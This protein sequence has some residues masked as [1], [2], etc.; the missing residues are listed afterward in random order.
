MF[1][2]DIVTEWDILLWFWWAGLPEGCRY[3]VTVN[4]NCP[5]SV[6]SYVSVQIAFYGVGMQNPNK[7]PIMNINKASTENEQL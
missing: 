2:K 7:Q 1:S 3:V 5:M 4:A 6:R